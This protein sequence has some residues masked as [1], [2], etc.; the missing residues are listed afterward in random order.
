MEI[1]VTGGT[2]FI[3]EALVPVLCAKG[4]GV[5]VLTRQSDPA[6]ISDAR[7][8]Q[9]LSQLETPIDVVINLAGASLAAKRWNAAYKD[10]MVNS[11]VLLTQRLGEYFRAVE[12][13]PVIWLNASA[14]GFYGPRG[15]ETLAESAD[16]GTGFAAELCRDWEAAAKKAAGDARLCLM[17]LGVVLDKEGGAY[18]QMAQP[19]QMGVANWIGDGEQ[20]LSWVHRDDVVA[21]I[22]HAMDNADVAGA[23]NVT[24]PT[25]VTSRGFCAAMRKVHRTLVAIPM[26]GVV[27]R[28]M[29]GEMADELL[30]TGQK[31]LPQALLSSG[32]NFTHADIDTALKAIET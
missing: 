10:E 13:R 4:H 29:V 12:K 11:R 22:C 1:L 21:A 25:P 24:A 26:P 31:V 15:D 23:V 8:I 5:T 3:G 32:F 16:T 30:I 27:M 20:W 28:A 9:E 19:F 14:I 7:F 6:Q 17:R 2:G 18:P